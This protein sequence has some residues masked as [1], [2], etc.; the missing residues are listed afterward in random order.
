MKRKIRT[1]IAVTN[2]DESFLV[3]NILYSCYG[4]MICCEI[5]DENNSSGMLLANTDIKL[6]AKFKI[7]NNE[8]KIKK[9]MP[10]TTKFDDNTIK[11]WRSL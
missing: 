10:R 8:N 1:G 9:R 2:W 11:W 4:Y 7:K 5:T 6:L 3:K